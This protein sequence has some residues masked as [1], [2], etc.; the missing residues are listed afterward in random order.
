MLFLLAFSSVLF[1]NCDKST[2]EVPGRAKGINGGF[3]V[4]KKGLPVN[5]R[6]STP[7]IDPDC[8]F[9]IVLDTLIY[10]EGKQS[11]KFCVKE[12]PCNPGFTN[13]FHG[14][15][16]GKFKGE[17]DYKVSFWIKNDGAKCK[18]EL[19][20][21]ETGGIGEEQLIL[22]NEQIEDWKYYEYLS[23][24]PSKGWL[25]LSLAIIGPGTFWVDDIR[26]EKI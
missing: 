19:G 6:I 8:N 3:E 9:E 5:W 23:H 10:K 14:F 21:V 16:G 4:T 13:E 18:I 2:I 15:W 20:P 25:K 26:I 24:V 7:K 17:A 1:T 12:G 11:L 22:I